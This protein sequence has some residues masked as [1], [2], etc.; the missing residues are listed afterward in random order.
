MIIQNLTKNGDKKWG[1]GL[2][3][4]DEFTLDTVACGAY[5]DCGAQRIT[6]LD[7]GGHDAR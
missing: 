1:R 6:T 2:R 3:K 5:H 7:T 4:S